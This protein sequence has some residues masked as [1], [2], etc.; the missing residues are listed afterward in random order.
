M[1]MVLYST[2][3]VADILGLT[4]QRVDQLIR[5]EQLPYEKIGKHMFVSSGA[6]K[7]WLEK[8]RPRK[9]KGRPG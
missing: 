8:N 3:E 2:A 1:S 9:K 5:E 7:W 4:R 6:L